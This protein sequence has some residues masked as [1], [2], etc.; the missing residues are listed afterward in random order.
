MTVTLDLPVRIRYADD[1]A[2]AWSITGAHG[3]G[4]KVYL[5]LT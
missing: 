3:E 2:D 1:D 5:D 4:G